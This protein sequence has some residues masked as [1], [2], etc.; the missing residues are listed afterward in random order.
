MAQNSVTT[1]TMTRRF[2]VTAERV[3]DA[4]LNPVMMRRWLFTLERT[5]KVAKNEPFVG[6]AWEISD[7]RDG[8]LYT[9]IGRYLEIDR[10]RRL[11]FTFEMPQ[12]GNTVDTVT[13]EIEPLEDGC[14]MTFTQEIT[15]PHEEN[16][17]AADLEQALGEYRSST[18]HG[19]NLMFSGLKEILH[20]HLAI[21]STG[22]PSM[23][24]M[25]DE[26]LQAVFAD[27]LKQAEGSSLMGLRYIGYVQPDSMALTELGL[28]LV[29]SLLQEYV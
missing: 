21:Q 3:F 17:T 11:V 24:A 25:G 5:N 13:V 7:E 22:A 1:L 27:V 26:E 20:F 14:E 23:L 18:E 16:W 6:G 28:E 19:W 8:K 4:W 15:V 29:K 9:A 10:P 12:F 2:D